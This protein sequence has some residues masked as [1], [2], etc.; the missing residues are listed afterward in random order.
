MFEPYLALWSLTPDGQPLVT[1]SSRL[2]PVLR[3]TEPAMLKLMIDE[4]E[5]LGAALMDWWD[6]RGA[7]RVLCRDHNACLLERA[8]GKGRLPEMACSGNDGE[9]VRILCSVA[10]QLHTP[11]AQPPPNLVPLSRW[12]R[13]LELAAATHGGVLARCAE[14]ARILLAEP[15]DVRVL[16][17]DLHHGNVLDFGARCWLAIDP[18]G[19]IGE[20]GFDFA[21]IFLNPDLA[22]PETPV[23]TI[24][25]VLEQRLSVIASTASL[26]RHRLLQWIMAWTGLSAAWLL[27][28]GDSARVNWQIAE[29]V[30]AELDQ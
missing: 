14:T 25:A 20:R 9:A 11:Q 18:K 12:F 15:L 19:L 30:A 6:G 29:L 23:A 26:Q 22:A 27:N 3:G 16:H 7:A 13:D 8:T 28:D 21:N 4:E 2:L 24:P 17:G 10:E 1:A 5:R